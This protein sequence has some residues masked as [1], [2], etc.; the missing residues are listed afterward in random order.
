MK[1]IVSGIYIVDPYV[2]IFVDGGGDNRGA[3]PP[4]PW[5]AGWTLNRAKDGFLFYLL[6]HHSSFLPQRMPPNTFM[7]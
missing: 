7:L 2:E 1:L 6:G 3:A 4:P 5:G